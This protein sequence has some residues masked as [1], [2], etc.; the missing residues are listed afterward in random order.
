MRLGNSRSGSSPEKELLERLR[1]T[2]SA[3]LEMAKGIE[4]L[5]KLCERSRSVRLERR[6]ISDGREP[7]K[8][9]NWR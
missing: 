4:P 5:N 8:E 9:L 3:R 6:P 7:T 2:S 1:E